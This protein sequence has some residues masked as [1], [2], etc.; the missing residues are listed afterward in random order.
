MA[1][2]NIFGILSNYNIN[3]NLPAIL[4]AIRFTETGGEQYWKKRGWDDPTQATNIHS[5]SN[6]VGAFQLN[7]KWFKDFG[8]GVQKNITEDQARDYWSS[9]K[10]AKS[11]D[12]FSFTRYPLRP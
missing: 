3:D 5:G 2:N 11:F 7:P 6:E 9:R 4:D 12:S 10:I 8:F 1:Q